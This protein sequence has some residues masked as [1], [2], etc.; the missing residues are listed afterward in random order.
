MTEPLD[1]FL[2]RAYLDG[3][4][5]DAAVQAFE[6]RLIERPDLAELVE[7]DFALGLG[8]AAVDMERGEAPRSADVV[9][10]PAARPAARPRPLARAVPWLA[11]AGV[12]FAV[13]LGTAR[14]LEPAMPGLGSAALVYIDKVRSAPGATI[15]ARVPATGTVVLLVPVASASRC[16]VRVEVRQGDVVLAGETTS[17]DL[18]Y[19]NLVADASRLVPGDAAVKVGCVGEPQATYAMKLVR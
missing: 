17:D 13:G 6:I 4:M 19:A 7:A 8:L 10:L 11:A 14:L 1:Q 15:E 9:P 2:L 12:A 16:A 5:D 18:G 3:E